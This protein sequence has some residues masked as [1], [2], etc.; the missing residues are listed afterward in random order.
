MTTL[1]LP[2]THSFISLAAAFL[3][4]GSHH[5][6]AQV[7]YPMTMADYE[8]Q[9]YVMMDD[10]TTP[11]LHHVFTGEHYDL[12]TLAVGERYSSIERSH[13]DL[14]I[15]ANSNNEFERLDA[16]VD[17]SFI[18]QERLQR[19]RNARGYLIPLRSNLGEYDFTNQRFPVEL[20]MVKSAPRS[21]SSYHC[22]GAYELR[23]KNEYWSACLSANNLN[24]NEKFV[25]YFPLPD[26]VLARQIREN[27]SSYRIFALAE[28]VGKYRKLQGNEIR[29]QHSSIYAAAG[30]LPVNITG[31]LLTNADGTRIFASA[32]KQRDTEP[33]NEVSS[34]SNPI[35]K[36][37]AVAADSRTGGNDQAWKLVI[38]EKGSSFYTDT[39]SIRRIGPN[40]HTREL[41]DYPAGT[42]NGYNSTIGQYTY[43]CN[44]R[45]VT[46]T[47]LKSFEGNMGNGALHAESTSPQDFGV[48]RP[49]SNSEAMFNFA[50]NANP[51]SS[52]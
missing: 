44:R 30:L 11:L 2:T 41:A 8:A 20:R 1:P 15:K 46:R 52:L 26:L 32:I 14:R 34:P 36:M 13:Q 31:L 39:V 38:Q 45:T 18:V 42:M 50:C 51:M 10:I 22:A 3:L 40:V 43:N 27:K 21:S 16:I 12:R 17:W 25:R 33:K 5:A 48:V 6:G 19:L 28:P 35:S 29:Y 37:A 4:L 49:G 24:E 47:S 9:G 7:S 23:A